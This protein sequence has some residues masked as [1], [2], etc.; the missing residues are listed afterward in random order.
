MS[1]GSDDENSVDSFMPAAL[2]STIVKPSNI[3]QC[4]EALVF[5]Q[6]CQTNRQWLGP[7]LGLTKALASCRKSWQTLGA[8]VASNWMLHNICVLVTQVHYKA[9]WPQAHW[10]YC[11]SSSSILNCIDIRELIASDIV[12]KGR[13]WGIHSIITPTRCLECGGG[14]GEG[15]GEYS[16]DQNI[17]RNVLLMDQSIFSSCRKMSSVRFPKICCF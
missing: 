9:D 3:T 1:Y 2:L 15:G 13:E 14:R 6:T 11:S 10:M 12:N 8:I 4:Q 16:T 17:P 5:S 7:C